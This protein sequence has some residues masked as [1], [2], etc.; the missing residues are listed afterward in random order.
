MTP[1]PVRPL[2][3][4]EKVSTLKKLN[5]S[6]CEFL[7]TELNLNGKILRYCLSSP[8]SK[9]R[10]DTLFTKEPGTIDWLNTFR[11]GEVFVD[12][13]ANVGVFALYAAMICGARVYAFE[14]ESQNYA[15][16]CRSIFLNAAHT[17]ITA[18]CA[19][20][21][22]APMEVSQLLL[23]DMGTGLSH[24]DFS[25]PSHDYLPAQRPSQGSIGFSLDFLVETGAVP[26]P[27]HV[28][29]DVDGHEAKVIAGMNGVLK[30]GRVRSLLV[31]CHFGIPTTK[32][33]VQTLLDDGWVYNLDQVRLSSKGLRTAQEVDDQI[34][35]GTFE[36][37]FIFARHAD[38]LAFATAALQRYH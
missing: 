17:R 6:N 8:V 33:L 5:G 20:L 10:I 13:G 3:V 34:R 19:A 38:D 15:E 18:F 35:N 22:A 16:L 28:K 11:P 24:H 32:P 36:G 7:F 27:D 23:F 25:V 31:E 26:A 21:G 29:I 30:S 14:P 1:N 37:N 12:V 4:M 2:H 9:W